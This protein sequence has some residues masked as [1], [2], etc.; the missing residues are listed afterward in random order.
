MDAAWPRR[1]RTRLW[2]VLLLLPALAGRFLV[3]PGFM[4]GSSAGHSPTMQMC[5][6][7]GAL[8]A[9]R[10]APPAPT[11]DDGRPAGQHTTCVFAATGTAA[12][13]PVAVPVLDGPGTPELQPSLPAPSFA[14]ATPHQP[15][16]PRAPPSSS[17]DRLI[18]A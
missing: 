13:P 9:G 12:P 16:S 3:P 14:R 2:V 10:D 6:G 17:R 4:P 7:A 11:G 15:Y 1:R 8:P 18:H 5:H